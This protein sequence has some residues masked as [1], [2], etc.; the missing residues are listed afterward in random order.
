M[1]KETLAQHIWRGEQPLYTD[2]T[3]GIPTALGPFVMAKV[4]D[5]WT[6][7]HVRLDGA[8]GHGE[9]IFAAYHLMLD[10]YEKWWRKSAR[11]Q[12]YFIGSRAEMTALVKIGYTIDVE[13]RLSNLQ[14][15]N[16]ISL[17]ILATVDGGKN[18]EASYHMR[19][20]SQRRE[21]E[22]FVINKPILA[23]IERLS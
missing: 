2:Q 16:P 18:V 1:A 11:P 8:L 7:S 20:A 19:F 10:A 17:S 23:E 3:T 13:S 15:G 9:T 4:N 12:V 6:F 5:G 21:G 14:V 22:W